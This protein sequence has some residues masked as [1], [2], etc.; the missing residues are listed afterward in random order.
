MVALLP[1]PPPK[2]EGCRETIFK[3]RQSRMVAI[4]PA[5]SPEKIAAKFDKEV[6]VAEEARRAQESIVATEAFMHRHSVG[7][8]VA[9]RAHSRPPAQP[10]RSGFTTGW[11]RKWKTPRCAS[12]RARSLCRLE[13]ASTTGTTQKRHAAALFS[14]CSL[15]AASSR[16]PGVCAMCV[17]G[18]CIVC[19]SVEVVC[20]RC[21]WQILRVEY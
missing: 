6:R 9:R 15:P 5:P 14:N 20:V 8:K 3:C 11:W 1:P 2:L 4:K 21:V 12:G 13:C 7:D 18:V 19:R 10:G 16:H 17:L